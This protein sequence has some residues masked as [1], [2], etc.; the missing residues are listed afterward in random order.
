MLTR[1]FV[2]ALRIGMVAGK[3]VEAVEAVRSSDR[4]NAP[5]DTAAVRSYRTVRLNRADQSRPDCLRSNF[6][7]ASHHKQRSTNAISKL[8]NKKFSINVFL[9]N[10]EL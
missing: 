2:Q 1:I 9:L 5:L 6:R 8:C 10:G 4:S 3:R 7:R